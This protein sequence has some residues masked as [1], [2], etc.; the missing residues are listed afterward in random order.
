MRAGEA[1][2]CPVGRPRGEAVGQIRAPFAVLGWVNLPADPYN[3]SKRL[4]FLRR[5]RG[6]DAS[7]GHHDRGARNGHDGAP[8]PGHAHACRAYTCA[9]GR[10]SAS[11]TDRAAG[12]R[13]RCCGSRLGT[14]RQSRAFMFSPT[15]LASRP[16][17]HASTAPLRRRGADDHRDRRLGDHAGDDEHAAPHRCHLSRRQHVGGRAASRVGRMLLTEAAAACGF[18]CHAVAIRRRHSIQSRGHDAVNSRIA[19]HGKELS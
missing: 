7:L 16:P 8:G 13:A 14:L 9:I 3:R 15:G 17:G 10:R 5:L 18:R 1:R 6:A 2:T 19:R 4:R 12:R 11:G